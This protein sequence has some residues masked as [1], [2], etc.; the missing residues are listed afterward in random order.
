MSANKLQVVFGE[1]TEKN[2][3][4]LKLLNS[5]TFP[6]KYNDEFYKGLLENTDLTQLAYFNDILIGA[7][8]CRVENKDDKKKL[9]IMTLGV[10]SPYRKY[11]IGG[12]LLSYVLD[13]VC[14]KDELKGTIEE[15]Y[16]HVQVNNDNAISF[17]KKFGFEIVETLKDYYKRIEPRDCYV[18]SKKLSSTS[19]DQ[20]S[21]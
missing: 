16:L 17:Y 6:V 2:L 12:K 9:Y 10:L 14:N 13:T 4:Q 20:T 7:I 18:L 21:K 3:G 15:V 19:T 5:V 11:G 1:I 8:C